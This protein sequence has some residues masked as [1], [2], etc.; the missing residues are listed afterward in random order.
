MDQ[1]KEQREYVSIAELA[2]ILGISRVAVFKQVQRGAIPAQRFG[3]AYA[4][5]MDHVRSM[6]NEQSPNPVAPYDK[7]PQIRKVVKKVV[8]EYGETLKLLG[9]E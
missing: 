6:R 5:P 9:K 3:R 8:D 4:I 7:K 1:K 2:K